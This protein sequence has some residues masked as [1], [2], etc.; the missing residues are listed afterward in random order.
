VLNIVAAR[1]SVA[2]FIELTGEFVGKDVNVVRSI[3]EEL[4]TDLGAL[5]DAIKVID[6]AGKL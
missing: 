4:G 2:S 5:D 3:A 6:V 1:G